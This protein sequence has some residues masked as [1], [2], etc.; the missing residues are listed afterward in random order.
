MTVLPLCPF[1]NVYWWKTV[2]TKKEVAINFDENYQKQTW[3]NRYDILGANGKLNL[4]VPVK[5]PSG[6]RVKTS[7]IKIFNEDRQ[8]KNIHWRSIKSAYGSSP[9]WIYYSDAL[10]RIYESDHETL[11]EFSMESVQFVLEELELENKVEETH[12]DP[13]NAENLGDLFK[14]S[15]NNFSYAP[16][17]Q[18]FSDRFPFENNLSILDVLF[19]LGPETEAYLK[20]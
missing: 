3:R 19:N 14:P 12:K 11:R 15:K 9:F 17:I 13:E 16:Y 20:R 8:W 5:K 4:T 10:Q 1:G 6:S 2:L 7:E 18:V